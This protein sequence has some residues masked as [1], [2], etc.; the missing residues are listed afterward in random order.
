MSKKRNNT[1]LPGGVLPG[2]I[3]EKPENFKPINKDDVGEIKKG[4]IRRSG[5]LTDNML[6]YSIPSKQPDLFTYLKDETK[7]EIEETGVEITQI[8]EGI[9]LTPPET[10]IVDC[11]CKLLHENSQTI[12]P[13]NNYY[14]GNMGYELVAF[15]GDRSTPA[16]KLGFTLYELTKEY[17]GGEAIS[18]KDVDNVKQILTELDNKKFLLSYVETSKKID[19]SRVENKIE[20]FSRLIQILKL[21]QTE[22]SKENIEVSKKEETIVLLNPIFRRQIDSKFILFPEDILRRTIIAY[23]SHNLSDIALRLRDYLIRELS[24]KRYEPEITQE[25]LFYML[26]EKWMKESRKKKIKEYLDKAIET[27]TALGLLL[28]FEI[29]TSSKGEP[30][31]I[32][33]LNEDWE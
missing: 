1:K 20:S 9:K 16:P 15:G 12:E 26:S 3:P 11:L 18:G 30:K 21:S 28:S 31:Y 32:F 24:S 14:S 5:H 23:G 22:F 13:G 33:H 6:K 7:R 4:K 8:V 2:F 10:K 25:K 17:K 27:A 29:K 19:G